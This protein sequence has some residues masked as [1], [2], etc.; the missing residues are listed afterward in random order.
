MQRLA[1]LVERVAPT[2][3]PVLVVGESGTGKELVAA[4]IQR[5]SRRAAAPFVTVN[6]AAVAETL[7]ES[8]LFGH[9]K[10]AFS[11]AEER[12]LGF[13][14]IAEGG[15]IFLDEIGDMPLSMQPK[16]LRVL[17]SGEF[18]R[19]G[20]NK[21][22]FADVR[23]LAATNMSLPDSVRDGRFREDLM[24]R[25]NTFT[26][27][28]PPLRDRLG[29]IDELVELFLRELGA[30]GPRLGSDAMELLRAYPWPGN[31][32]ELRNVVRRAA[33]LTDGAEIEPCDLPSH[34]LARQ[35]PS[36][37][38]DSPSF[39]PSLSLAE[40]EKIH[41]LAMLEECGGN[42]TKAARRLGVAVK[43][44]YNKLEAWQESSPGED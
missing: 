18:R 8:E 38:P 25:I 37:S 29:D 5:Q 33:V 42:K 32:R 14:E 15:T 30:K 43:T 28:V 21:T 39:D 12:R 17:Q 6:C 26:I 23:V 35:E 1:R 20:G 41:V 9:E 11:G 22:L 34:I 27:E 2:D 7:L 36:P 24:H 3:D 19:V 10:G 40:V 13:F 4:A 44:L 31:V 16:L